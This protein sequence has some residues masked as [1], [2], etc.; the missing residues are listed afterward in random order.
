MLEQREAVAAYIAEGFA[1]A[2]RGELI[3]GDTV[4]EVLRQRRAPRLKAGG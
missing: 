3:D 1:Q 2:Q 4:L